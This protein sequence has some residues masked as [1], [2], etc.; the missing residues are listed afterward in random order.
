MVYM[1]VCFNI[2]VNSELLML[3]QC[4][5]SKKQALNEVG[6]LLISVFCALCSVLCIMLIKMSESAFGTPS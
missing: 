3:Y 6:A 1:S 4:P 5:G 2:I